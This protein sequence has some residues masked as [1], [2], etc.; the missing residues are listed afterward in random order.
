MWMAVS[1]NGIFIYG[2]Y[3][4]FSLFPIAILLFCSFVYVTYVA[5]RHEQGTFDALFKTF[6]LRLERK[7]MAVVFVGQTYNVG[8]DCIVKTI[9]ATSLT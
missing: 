3:K 5:K 6:F 8:E 4:N 1:R 2:K 9:R 7:L